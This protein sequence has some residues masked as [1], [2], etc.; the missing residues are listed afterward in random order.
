MFPKVDQGKGTITFQN[1][2]L[3][4]SQ[5]KLHIQSP[6]LAWAFVGGTISDVC[7]NERPD[8]QG[9]KEWVLQI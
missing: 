3:S 8:H 5:Q 1:Q 6:Y 7:E 9:G 2:R 4:P